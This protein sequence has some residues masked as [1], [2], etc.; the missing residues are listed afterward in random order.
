MIGA[1]GGMEVALARLAGVARVDAVEYNPA[2]VDLVRQTGLKYM[3]AETVVYSREYLFIKD[4]HE[5]GELGKIQYMQASHPQDM[6]GWPGY[7]PAWS[8]PTCCAC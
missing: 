2:I 6:E 1:G 4:L 3:M 5:K 8:T 7:W